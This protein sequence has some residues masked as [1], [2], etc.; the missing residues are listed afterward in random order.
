M[1]LKVTKLR[2]RENAMLLTVVM[3]V[4]LFFDGLCCVGVL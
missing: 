2:V 3:P 4:V 1:L